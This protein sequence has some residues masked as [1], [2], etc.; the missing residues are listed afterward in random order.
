[1]LHVFLAFEAISAGQR[2]AGQPRN[3]GIEGVCLDE[4][5]GRC[6]FPSSGQA[7]IAKGKLLPPT[8]NPH[9]GLEVF[10]VGGYGKFLAYRCCLQISDVRRGAPIAKN[11]LG[12]CAP[13][14]QNGW[15]PLISIFRSQCCTFSPLGFGLHSC[16][17]GTQSGICCL[18]L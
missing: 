12:G 8:W 1:M 11:S 17:L 7:A 14:Q 4:D 2:R 16:L 13:G 6:G 9:E 5:S 10:R 18:T 3:R 15:F